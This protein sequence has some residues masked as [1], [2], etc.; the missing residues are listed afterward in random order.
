[1]FASVPVVIEVWRQR[2]QR[3][4][5]LRQ[6]CHGIPAHA[7]RRWPPWRSSRFPG[8]A[9]RGRAAWGGGSWPLLE[10]S[11]TEDRHSHRGRAEL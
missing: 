10:V 6:L 7:R 3:R 2:G 4:R 5:A 8:A 9:L 1:M 11:P